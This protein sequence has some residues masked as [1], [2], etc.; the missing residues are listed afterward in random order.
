[1]ILPVKLAALADPFFGNHF[2]LILRECHFPFGLLAVQLNDTRQRLHPFKRGLQGFL[3][4]A[5]FHRF[6]FKSGQP[7]IETFF[8][9][10]GQ[11]RYQDEHHQ[12]GKNNRAHKELWNLA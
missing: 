7:H 1:M 11:T 5:F 3:G 2:R 4:N 12:N 10:H 9:R 6:L 8:I